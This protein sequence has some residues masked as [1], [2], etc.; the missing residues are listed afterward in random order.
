MGNRMKVYIVGLLLGLGWLTG[1]KA[2][3]VCPVVKET[4]TYAIKGKDTLAFDKYECVLGRDSLPRPVVLFA[5]GGGFKGGDRARSSYVPFFR[6]LAERGYVVVSADYR[7][8]LKDA[9]PDSAATAAGFVSALQNAIYTAVEDYLDA[10]GY[11]LKH[12][13]EWNV[14][15]DKVIAIGSSAGAITVL[16][17]E[18]ELANR[19]EISRRLPAS[20][21]YAGVVSFAGAICSVDTPV[22]KQV[23]C[24]IMLFHGDA[25]R[26]VPYREV[27]LENLGGLWGSAAIAEQLEKQ[28]ASCYFYKVRNAGHEVA[29]VPMEKNRN[30]VLGFLERQVLRGEKLSVV[31]EEK[32]PCAT[33][34]RKD[35][36]IGDYIQNNT[37]GDAG[38]QKIKKNEWMKFLPDTMPV[39]K[40][41]IPGTHDSGTTKGGSFLITQGLEIPR[42]LQEGIRAF[43]IRLEKK[44]KKLGVFHSYAFQ[45]I[46]W[47]DD[48]LPAFIHFLQEHPSEMLIVSLKKEGGDTA[49]Y[50][51]LLS[52]SLSDPEH[53]KY[54]VDDFSPELTLKD[55]RGK[56]LFLHR[57]RAME[58]YPGAACVGWDDNST[59][60]LTLRNKDGK[61]GTVLLQDEYQYESGK[62]ADKKIAACIRNFDKVCAEPAASRRWGISFVSATGLPSGTPIVFAD[63]INEPVAAYLKKAGK[64]NCG[65]VFIDF[66]EGTGG[67]NLVEYLIGSNLN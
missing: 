12:S 14:N 27:R 42:Q 66:V 40:I 7:T 5:F 10:T 34:V 24:P 62:E 31:T 23:P 57:D 33:E 8:A 38:P 4:G 9:G 52:A 17:A 44:N 25:D 48:V 32:V 11:I 21:N 63:Q 61:E 30:D 43:D 41:S 65:I 51:S 1:A 3:T 19:T 15:P 22:W 45:D 26:T 37:Q 39:C 18:Y 47:E 28:Y 50:A 46:Y 64:R 60:L 58:H 35:F 59:C 56:I 53:R 29:D 20:F 16:Q 36:T 67:R 6:F 2:A 49:D 13:K 55:C 54:F